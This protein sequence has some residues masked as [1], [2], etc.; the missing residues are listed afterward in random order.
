MARNEQPDLGLAEVLLSLGEELREANRTASG[1]PSPSLVWD[2][3]VVEVV[4]GVNVTARGGVKFSVLGFGAEG[5]ADRESTRT[6]RAQ[7]RVTP[8]QTKNVRDDDGPT[9]IVVGGNFGSG[10]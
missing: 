3:A 8:F 9:G 1:L 6:I 2:D 10:A 4:L 7:V 5:G